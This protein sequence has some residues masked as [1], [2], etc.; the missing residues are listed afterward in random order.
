MK[1]KKKSWVLKITPK[2]KQLLW[3]IA[4]VLTVARKRRKIS[5]TAVAKAIGVDRRTIGEIEKGN[6]SVSLG[7]FLLYLHHLEFDR[8]LALL[9]DPTLDYASLRSEITRAR[10]T[11]QIRKGIDKSKV[12]F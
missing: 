9:F 6:P 1:S 5:V 10:K 4:D 2:V 3:E 7:V 11:G 8:G 12:D